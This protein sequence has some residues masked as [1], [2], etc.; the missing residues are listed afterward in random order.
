MTIHTYRDEPKFGE[1]D[2]K[3]C[4]YA[5]DDSGHIPFAT[6]VCGFETRAEAEAACEAAVMGLAAQRQE[7]A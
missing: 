7:A 3:W 4:A 1:T 2:A 5:S 6:I